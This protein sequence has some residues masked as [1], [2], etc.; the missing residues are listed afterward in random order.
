MKKSWRIAIVAGAFS[1]SF[2]GILICIA[3]LSEFDLDERFQ[4]PF[5]TMLGAWFCLVVMSVR[6]IKNVRMN[7]VWLIAGTIL[8]TLSLMMWPIVRYQ[9]NKESSLDPP[10]PDSSGVLMLAEFILVFPCF[11]LACWLV[12]FHWTRK[13]P[14][15]TDPDV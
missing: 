4:W 3:L 13:N 9:M 5:Y 10:L 14:A 15:E 12:R 8:G 11:V 7:R 2:P 6:W 1:L